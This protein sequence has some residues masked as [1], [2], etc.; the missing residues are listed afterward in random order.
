MLV[1]SHCHLDFLDLSAY[2]GLVTGAI[3]AAAAAGVDTLLCISVDAGNVETVVSIAEAHPQVYASVGTHPLNV[4]ERPIEPDRLEA[5][6]R[7]KRVVA[8]GETGLDYHYASESSA[9]QRESFERHLELAIDLDKP[10]VV[11]TR[12]ARADTLDLLNAFASRGVTGVLHCFTED[13]AMAKAA[14]DIGLYISLSGIVTFRNAAALREVAR[15]VPADRLLLETDSPWLA[16]VPYRGRSNEP[17]YL[18]AVAGCVAGE[19]GIEVEQLTTLTRQNFC[20]LFG[21]DLPMETGC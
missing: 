9:L 6:A 19:R 1:D 18:P 4:G 12:D 16:P 8:I 11:H 2:D 7:R 13:W 5:L 10:V 20:S 21:V 14:L 3:D 15:K 17:C